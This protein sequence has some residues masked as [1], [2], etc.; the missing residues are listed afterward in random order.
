MRRT[1]G[2]LTSLLKSSHTLIACVLLVSFAAHVAEAQSGRRTEKRGAS[3]PVA[4]PAETPA[5]VKPQPKK[6]T[7]PQT[8]LLVAFDMAQSLD[9]TFLSPE[10]VQ[11][12][13]SKRLSDSSSLLVTEGGRINR[14]EAIERAKNSTETFVV[15]VQL[16]EGYYSVDQR[17]DSSRPNMENFRINY[18]VYSP[19]TGKAKDSGVVYLNYR[20]SIV[21]LGRIRNEATCYPNVRGNEYVLLQ[22]SLEVARR[23]MNKFDLPVPPVCP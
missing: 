10:R 11:T 1:I 8:P 5:P 14:K 7:G 21:D 15:W 6:P 3:P 2:A 20:Q 12:W 17:S 23:I 22:A 18:Y 16:E 4:V 19:V 13:V 9:L